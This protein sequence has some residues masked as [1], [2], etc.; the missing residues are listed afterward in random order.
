MI[1]V[2]CW[3][4]FLF[5]LWKMKIHLLL[6]REWLPLTEN[7][8]CKYVQ[9]ECQYKIVTSIISYYSLPFPTNNSSQAE[10]GWKSVD[11]FI[12]AENSASKE[13]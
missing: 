9:T 10:R 6:Y 4:L 12:L 7:A 5:L 13:Y 1:S 3:L 8:L 2:K 11:S